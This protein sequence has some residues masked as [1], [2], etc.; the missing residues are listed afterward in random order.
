[1]R[2]RGRARRTL[3]A[4]A[5]AAM[6]VVFVPAV[7]GAQ[8]ATQTVCATIDQTATNWSSSVTLTQFDP[9]LGVLTE[10]DLTATGTIVQTIKM[11]SKDAAPTTVTGTGT[12]TITVTPPTAPN[13]VASPTNVVTHNFT[14]FDG[15]VDFG[16]T[17]GS[18]DAGVTTSSTATLS[19]YTPISDFNGPGSLTMPVTASA[20]FQ[21]SGAGNLV[22]QVT[23]T[24]GVNVCAT[25]TYLL[26]TPTPTSTP[27]P[28]VT[29]TPTV[30]PTPTNTPTATP[31]RTPTNTPTTTPT[32]TNTPTPT[33]TPTA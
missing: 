11:E 4:I 16:G 14:A 15:T 8:T 22:T 10:V 3:G 33:V 9:S 20:T 29:N 24:A 32:P 31:T 2:A 21:A 28:T 18:T 1:M 13:L 7:A 5:A 17:S 12:A 26:P 19:P 30:T 23:T 6:V 27:T 25:Y